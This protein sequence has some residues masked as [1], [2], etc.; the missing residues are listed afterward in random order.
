MSSRSVEERLREALEARATSVEP[1]DGLAA[2]ERRLVESRRRRILVRAMVIGA[3][4]AAVIIAGVTIAALD[5]DDVGLE[6]VPP[7]T[8]P[9]VTVPDAGTGPV[10]TTSAPTAPVTTAPVTAADTTAT[11][12]WP[13]IWPPPGSPL[14]ASPE[15]AAL[16]FARDFLGMGPDANVVGSQP[17]VE[18][19]GVLVDVRPRPVGQLITHVQTR[20]A[21][22]G[23]VVEASSADNIEL[24]NPL[25]NSSVSA[26]IA[27]EGRSTTTEA[28]LYIEAR[29]LGSTQRLG[30][31]IFTMGAAAPDPLGPFTASLDLPSIDPGP[32][33]LVLFEDDLTGDG[34]V[35]SATVVPVLLAG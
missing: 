25:A 28:A 23:W 13:A 7:A 12:G 16:G 32:I 27:V 24:A 3:S 18:R 17:M 8:E 1:G 2:I 5:D 31:Q 4:A 34:A 10:V 33:V 19:E 14:F 11:D 21:G 9:A 35:A 26:P 20:A 6:V 29:R 15:E 22:T 30:E